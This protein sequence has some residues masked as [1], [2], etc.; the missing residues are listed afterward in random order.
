[1]TFTYLWRST[2]GVRR[3][4]L[5]TDKKK[6]WN[7]KTTSHTFRILKSSKHLFWRQIWN[8]DLTRFYK[9]SDINVS[10]WNIAKIMIYVYRYNLAMITFVVRLL[11]ILI[12]CK[13]VCKWQNWILY[14]IVRHYL[15]LQP[16]NRKVFPLFQHS[17]NWKRLACLICVYI[18]LLLVSSSE[19]IASSLLYRDSQIWN[20]VYGFP[21]V[22]MTYG[23]AY[24]S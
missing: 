6:M 3:N 5:K 17:I 20:Y 1:M 12:F 2:I 4:W 10:I 18:V 13:D 14:L 11:P 16:I 22:V 23:I 9:Y 21:K 19:A 24:K 8:T 7:I 15:F